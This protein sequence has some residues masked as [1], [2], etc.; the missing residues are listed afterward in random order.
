MASAIGATE[1][2]QSILDSEGEINIDDYINEPEINLNVDIEF[3]DVEFSY[4]TRK[5]MQVLK[6]INLHIKAGE[7]VALVGQSGSGKSTIVQLLMKF[8]DLDK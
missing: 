7:K 1:R 3:R 6:G 5:D 4:P 2:V 8:Y